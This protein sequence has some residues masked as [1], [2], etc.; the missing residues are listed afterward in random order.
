MDFFQ[1]S[2]MLAAVIF[3]MGGLTTNQARMDCQPRFSVMHMKLATMCPSS[4]ERFRNQPR[5]RS[6]WEF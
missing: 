5:V 4:Q 2:W 3:T 1:S 6:H